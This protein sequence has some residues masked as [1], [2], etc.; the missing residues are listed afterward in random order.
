[1]SSFSHLTRVFHMFSS[2]LEWNPMVHTFSPICISC[3]V[4][5]WHTRKLPKFTLTHP[6]GSV[7]RVYIIQKRKTR[8]AVVQYVYQLTTNWVFK[9][10]NPSG[11]SCSHL[12]R[13]ALRPTQP[14]VQGVP[15]VEWLGHSINDP[16][17]SS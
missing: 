5:T 10:S 6:V 14:F 12:S 16:P 11:V 3:P 8:A 4:W 9:G 17:P 13:L 1:M 7:F 15:G 2:C